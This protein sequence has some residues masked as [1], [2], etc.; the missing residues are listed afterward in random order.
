MNTLVESQLQLTIDKY[1]DYLSLKGRKTSTLKRYKY[2]ILSCYHY[3]LKQNIEIQS[4]IWRSITTR[5]YED[6][7]AML[8]SELHYSDKTIHRIHV[9]LN[10][11]LNYL[12]EINELEINPVSSIEITKQPDRKLS[13]THFISKIEQEKLIQILTSR[14][15]LTDKQ[16]KSRPFL[17]ERNLSIVHLMLHFGLT[18]KEIVSIQM[19]HIHFEQNSITIPS[20]RNLT[21]TKDDKE[22]LF[23]YYHKIPEPVRPNYHSND[24]FFVAFDYNRGTY[25]WVYETDSPKAL[26]E[27][28]V[29]KMIRLEVKRARLRKGISAQYLRNTYILNLIETTTDLEQLMYHTGLTSKLALKRYIDFYHNE[30]STSSLKDSL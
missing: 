28:S 27:I 14:E 10:K 21:L 3:I 24:P 23:S 18:L 5:D 22:I 4:N 1:S 25:R 6:Y 12:V 17:F 9:A 15:N 30:K 26:T 16:L 29:Q 20:K 7:F 8:S 13:Q 2:D 11:F 19:N